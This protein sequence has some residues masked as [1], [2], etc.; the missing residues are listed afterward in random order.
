MRLKKKIVIAVIMMVI[1]NLQLTRKRKKQFSYII[2]S[3]G[4]YNNVITDPTQI[5]ER[6][7]RYT[8]GYIL[9]II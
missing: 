9:F 3:L 1:Y 6:I 2:I 5:R 8:V 7:Q 4:S